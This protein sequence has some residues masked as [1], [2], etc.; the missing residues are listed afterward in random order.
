[1]KGMGKISKDI[2]CHNKG[3]FIP[4]APHPSQVISILEIQ[5]SSESMYYVMSFQGK[6]L[7]LPKHFSW[8]KYEP[9]SGGEKENP[10]LKKKIVYGVSIF[11]TSKR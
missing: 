4:C 10:K 2:I 11:S 9:W 5:L 7:V 1:M 6:T 3:G 8:Q